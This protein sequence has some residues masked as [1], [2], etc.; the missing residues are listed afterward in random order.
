MRCPYC[1]R[2]MKCRQGEY[3]YIE[4]GLDNVY[5]TDVELWECECG[6]LAAS[7]PAIPEL[8]LL[9]G[10][11]LVKKNA[12]LSGPEIRFLRKNMGI[13]AKGLAGLLGVDKATVSRWENGKQVPDRSTDRLIRLLYA[14]QKGIA[15]AALVE[16]FP[17]IA[18][19]QVPSEPF[20]VPRAVWSHG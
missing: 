3:H 20:R 15:M 13:A 11:Y 16:N 4:S 14:A 18:G 6:E 8:H 19:E 10:Q 7:I 17:H 1:G 9:I 5:L 12:L 2:E